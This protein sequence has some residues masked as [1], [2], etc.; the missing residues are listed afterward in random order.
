MKRK[1]EEAKERARIVREEAA[2]AK[3]AEEAARFEDAEEEEEEDDW[4]PGQA[5]GQAID[6]FDQRDGRLGRGR[7][8]GKGGGRGNDDRKKVFVGNLSWG[9]DEEMLTEFFEEAVGKVSFV[10]IAT[11]RETGQPRGFAHVEFEDPDSV[12]VAVSTLNGADLDGRSLRVDHA[13]NK[14]DGGSSGRTDRRAARVEEAETEDEIRQRKQR[15]RFDRERLERHKK[16]DSEGNRQWTR[17]WDAEKEAQP[18]DSDSVRGRGTRQYV[19]VFKE[20]EV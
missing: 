13:G 11:D 9:V 7:K 20:E 3:K 19:P 1:N 17:E 16:K 6:K 8:G 10:R 5:A 18:S 14:P 4:C 15:E 12:E 2:A